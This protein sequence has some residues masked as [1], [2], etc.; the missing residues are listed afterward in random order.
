MLN[1][2]MAILLLVATPA[3]AAARAAHGLEDRRPGRAARSVAGNEGHLRRA[4]FVT[5]DAEAFW[6]EWEKPETPHVVTTGRIARDKPVF[7]MLLFTG[8][9]AGPD[10]NCRL[11]AKFRMK[12]P[13]GADYGEPSGGLAYSGPPAP[14]SNLKLSDATLGFRLDPPDPL[15]TYT[16]IATLTDEIAGIPLTVE[17]KVEAV[18]KI[19]KD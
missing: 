7:A 14:G 2:P 6:K 11:T 19:E 13:Q 17:Q 15:G 18:A 1:L 3:A 4:M 5:P 8:C 12:D 10:G 16:I 9:R